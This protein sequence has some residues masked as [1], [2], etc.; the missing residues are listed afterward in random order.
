MGNNSQF[1]SETNQQTPQ[2]QLLAYLAIL[3]TANP[4]YPQ[5]VN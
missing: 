1:T 4:A 5:K 3:L 2:Q